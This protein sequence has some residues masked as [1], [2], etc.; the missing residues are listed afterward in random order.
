MGTFVLVHGAWCGS[1]AWEDVEP[2]LRARGHATYAPTLTGLAERSHLLSPD[3]N[4]TTHVGDVVGVIEWNDLEDVVLV[5]HSYGGMVISGVIEEVP[6]RICSAVFLDAMVPDDGMSLLDYWPPERARALVAAAEGN[7]GFSV[8]PVISAS[9]FGTPP[10]LCE[11]IDSRLRPHPLATLQQKMTLTGRREALSKR[12][13]VGALGFQGVLSQFRA[14]TEADPG[15]ES[16][17]VPCGHLLMTEM[18]GEVAELLV[19]AI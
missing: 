19:G 8:P 17:T 1:W 2:L 4:L 5:G 16:F 7:D 11:G 18:P 3:V 14:L 9:A 6:Q 10:E 12:I 15:W 13:Y